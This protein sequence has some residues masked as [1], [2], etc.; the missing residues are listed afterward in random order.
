MMTLMFL[1]A[2]DDRLEWTEA[3]IAIV[4]VGGG[5]A[6]VAIITS[7]LIWQ[8]GGT[9]RA[10]MSVARETA[11]RELASESASAQ[12]RT[13][14]ELTRVASELADLRTRTAEMERMLKE[15]G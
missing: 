7:V 10:R 13:A 15:V 4:A 8:I 9:W 2:A 6:L 3:W 5:M 12:A 1:Q 14:D 11:Y